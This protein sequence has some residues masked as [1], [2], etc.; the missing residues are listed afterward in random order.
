VCGFPRAPLACSFSFL[1]TTTYLPLRLNDPP[2]FSWQ[3][4]VDWARLCEQ[5]PLPL[6]S[7]CFVL[8]YSP[9]KLRR[10]YSTCWVLPADDFVSCL[11]RWAVDLICRDVIWHSSTSVLRLCHREHGLTQINQMRKLT[12]ISMLGSPFGTSFIFFIRVY[13][14]PIIRCSRSPRQLRADFA[15]SLIVFR[16]TNLENRLSFPSFV[17][18]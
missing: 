12:A 8:R 14:W 16:S 3:H 5:L 7:Q 11:R 1:V 13:L 9:V 17:S 18:S 10:A 4:R 2:S 15:F 6:G